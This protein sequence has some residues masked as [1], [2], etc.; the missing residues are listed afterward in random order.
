MRQL[1]ANGSLIHLKKGLLLSCHGLRHQAEDVRKTRLRR[2]SWPRARCGRV[3]D[4]GF[5]LGLPT[6]TLVLMFNCYRSGFEL[7]AG[8]LSTLPESLGQLSS[9]EKLYLE[10]N[11]LKTLPES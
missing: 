1:A 3:R 4:R 2:R 8:D 5:A 10:S 11:H 7:L 9:L 6:A